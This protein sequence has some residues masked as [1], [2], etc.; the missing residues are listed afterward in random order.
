MSE[1]IKIL[2]RRNSELG[3]SE[4]KRK[5]HDLREPKNDQRNKKQTLKKK[6]VRWMNSG[7]SQRGLFD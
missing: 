2:F 5:S 4:I 6:E 1:S 3:K 7:K